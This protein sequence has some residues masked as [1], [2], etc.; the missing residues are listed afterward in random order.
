[1]SAT[2]VLPARRAPPKRHAQHGVAAVEFALVAIVFLTVVFGML[3]LG[4]IIYMFNTLSDVT[5]TAARAA[6]NI[7][8]R[9]TAEL[10]RAR[11]RAMFRDSP[12]ELPFGAPLTDQ[13]IQIDYLY[14]KK[15]G[16]AVTTEPAASM[17]ASP[18]RNRLNC[19]ANHYGDGADAAAVCIRLVRVRIC[20]G[21][22]AACAPVRYEPIFPLLRLAPYLP[23]STTIV[24]AESLGYR[25]GDSM[26]P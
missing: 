9:N 19:L 15:V 6:S 7:D 4:R 26:N 21:A 1:M 23:M 22:G 5:R 25:P 13:D 11:A 17:P 2:N 20:R 16:S 14:L 18:G 8:W 10:N 3:E 24:T 12:G